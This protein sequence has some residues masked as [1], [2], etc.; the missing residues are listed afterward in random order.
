MALT[1]AQLTA[2]RTA[3]NG[4]PTW[5]AFPQDSDGYAGLAQALNQPANPAFTVWRTDAPT[6]DINDAI[7]STKFTATATI[8][9]SESEPLLSRKRGW[10][11][12]VN[13]KQMALQNLIAFREKI[14]A[15][16]PNIRASL[17]DCVTQLPTGALDANG[18]PALTSA[19]GASGVNVL[20]ACTRNATEAEKILATASQGSDTTGTVTAR[21]MGFE[22][23]LS[24]QEVE[25]AR[26]LP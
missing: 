14:N 15:A 17:R 21:V 3:I 7:D 16:K 9:G 5:S 13:V 11:D 2:L 18:K 22:G 6:A 4:S 8:S 23:F 20:N 25:A 1:T 12:E 10:I 19:G 26:N 24:A